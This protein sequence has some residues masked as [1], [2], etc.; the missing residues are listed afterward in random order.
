[1]MQNV[2]DMDLG[3]DGVNVDAMFFMEEDYIVS[4]SIY[5]T[6]LTGLDLSS[7][8]SYFGIVLDV[9]NGGIERLPDTVEDGWVERQFRTGP[10]AFPRRTWEA[11][12]SAKDVFCKYDDY[13][14]DWSVMMA[15]F[16]G[17]MVDRVLAPSIPQVHHIGASGMHTDKKDNKSTRKH[18]LKDATADVIL[19][20][21]H[22]KSIISGNDLPQHSKPYKNGGWG[23]PRDH[24]HC[25]KILG[26]KTE[27][28]SPLQYF[29]HSQG[30]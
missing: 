6:V 4:P 23:H 20:P 19:S 18:V 30:A 13:N 25:L 14:W 22:G 10:M 16:K 12:K 28:E 1:M 24:E 27:A 17:L 11:F 7:D 5:E 8:S 2:W 26:G 15:Q 9:T 21:F 3:I 29:F